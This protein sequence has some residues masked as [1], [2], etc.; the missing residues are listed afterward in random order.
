VA[1]RRR[2]LEAA[3]AERRRL[4]GRLRETTARRLAEL[5]GRLADARAIAGAT[6]T[7]AIVRAE[8][9]LARTAREL[10]QLAAGL[11]PHE[12][13]EH[14]LAVAVTGLAK[15][16]PVPAEA[17]VQVGRLADRLE[18]TV[19]FVCSEALA[20]VAKHAGASQVSVSIEDR[21]RTVSVE[22]RDD[23]RGG[24]DPRSIADRVEAMGGSLK[25]DSPVGRGTRL[26]AEIPR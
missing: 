26:Y 14:G 16:S 7:P 11:H 6:A 10:R 8:E 15:R 9:Q 20:N 17:I 3:D 13:S 23:G 24:A 4:E 25:V 2:L 5:E 12:L 21:G 18:A 1:S 22:I 19:F